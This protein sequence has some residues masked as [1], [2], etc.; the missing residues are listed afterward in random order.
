M[1]FQR[2][3]LILICAVS[4]LASAASGQF[5]SRDY[6]PLWGEAYENYGSIGYRD[7]LQPILGEGEHGTRTTSPID[8]FG[9]ELERRQY[10]PFGN[11]LADGLDVFRLQEFRGISPSRGSLLFE[12]DL[13]DRLFQNLMVARDD[14]RGWSNRVLIGQAIRTKFT[15]L[16]LSMSRF[17]G[18]YNR[19]ST[20]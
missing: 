2:L 5:I 17:R 4:A 6:Y 14:F 3:S 11:Y 20:V 13:S 10:D 12:S 19:G 18:S 9:V 1:G 16:T 15:S 7:V 8:G